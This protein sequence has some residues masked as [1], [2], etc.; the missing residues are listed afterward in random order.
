MW[1]AELTQA[2]HSLHEKEI[3]HKEINASNIFLLSEDYI[4]L[5]GDID[6]SIKV[7]V[8]PLSPSNTSFK[9]DPKKDF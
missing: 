7:I 5:G 3:L 4:I 1:L 8:D 6:Q 9:L 2:I